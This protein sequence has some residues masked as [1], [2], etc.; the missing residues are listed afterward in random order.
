M[1][2]GRRGHK[3]LHNTGHAVVCL[4]QG[5]QCGFAQE[6]VSQQLVSVPGQQQPLK[7]ENQTL[8]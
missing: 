2:L 5:G 6:L 1:N 7:G 3:P 8:S 4:N